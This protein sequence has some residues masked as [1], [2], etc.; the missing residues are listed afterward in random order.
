[1]ETINGWFL[2]ILNWIALMP[3]QGWAVLLGLGLSGGITQWMKRTFPLHLIFPGQ[4]ELVYKSS[5]RCASLIL[6]F[7]PTYFVWPDDV[8]RFWAALAVGFG[9]PTFY[10]MLTFFMY[11]KWP[12]LEQ[13]LSGGDV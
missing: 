10:K 6:G 1:M 12:Q 9:T 2:G 8:F 11:R 3:Q 4:T 7:I 13:K 5:I